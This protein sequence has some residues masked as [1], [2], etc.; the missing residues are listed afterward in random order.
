MCFLSDRLQEFKQRLLEQRAKEERE[1]ATKVTEEPVASA[2]QNGE[3]TS[4]D[5]ETGCE[6][7]PEEGGS[8][9]EEKADNV[10]DDQCQQTSVESAAI[11]QVNGHVE[12]PDEQNPNE[13]K[14]VTEGDS[15]QGDRP[16]SD[17]K[18]KVIVNGEVDVKPTGEETETHT[19]NEEEGRTENGEVKSEAKDTQTKS[20][21]DE[22]NGFING[23]LEI[24]A[25]PSELK[26]KEA[27][28][29]VAVSKAVIAN[30]TGDR[31][32]EVNGVAEGSAI[33]NGRAEE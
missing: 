5:K 7:E 11:V 22:V 3:E 21:S 9:A 28:A 12:E 33:T 1:G 18:S 26:S 29:D 17:A 31:D 30:G 13:E 32:A 25:D 6:K 24:T 23:V 20:D 16:A 8:P 10:Q 14:I 19:V 2:A 4:S 15:E 27:S